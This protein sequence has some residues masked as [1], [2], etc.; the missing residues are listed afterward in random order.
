[1]KKTAL[2]L[3]MALAVMAF[4]AGTA[5]A[6]RGYWFHS[7]SAGWTTYINITNTGNA[8]A[9][10][11]VTFYPITGSNGSTALTAL[12]STTATIQPNGQWNF[13]TAAIGVT[14]L[15]TTALETAVRGTLSITSNTTT[16]HGHATQANATFSGF[17]LSHQAGTI[18]GE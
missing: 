4:G 5:R 9:T 11:T 16:V 3:V 7:T 10:A 17:D 12:G 15:S 8:A 13:T 2:F 6:D 1:M 14:A 18:A